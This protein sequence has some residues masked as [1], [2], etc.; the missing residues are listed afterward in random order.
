[1][2]GYQT[3]S[4]LAADVLSKDQELYFEFDAA[5]SIRELLSSNNKILHALEA[6]SFKLRINLNSQIFSELR[7]IASNLGA[8]DNINMILGSL[9][10]YQNA[11]FNL[12]FRSGNELP[13]DVKEGLQKISENKLNSSKLHPEKIPPPIKLM[14]GH[15]LRNGTGN[16]HIFTGIDTN[17]IHLELHLPGLSQFMAE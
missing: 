5:K 17:M 2:A 6:L 16:L 8:P 3:A 9:A 10:L 14:A 15:L 11:Y 7:N 12:N 1:M 4:S 13:E